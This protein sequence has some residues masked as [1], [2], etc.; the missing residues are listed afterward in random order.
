MTSMLGVKWR[1]PVNEEMMRVSEGSSR[2]AAMAKRP[3]TGKIWPMGWP[4]ATRRTTTRI[5]PPRP[6][7]S[8]TFR[9]ISLIK[10]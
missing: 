1:M 8:M 4:R 3:S 6:T 10:R 7:V 9:G 5:M 2:T